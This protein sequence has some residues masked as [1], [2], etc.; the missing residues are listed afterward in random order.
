MNYSEGSGQNANQPG[1][2]E[3]GNMYNGQQ[4]PLQQPVM[5]QNPNKPYIS[6]PE[7][8]PPNSNRPAQPAPNPANGQGNNPGQRPPQKPNTKKDTAKRQPK[9]IVN[10][11]PNQ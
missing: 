1:N 7:T 6:R 11:Q 10:T 3:Q 5:N 2:K 9:K 8:V 4:K